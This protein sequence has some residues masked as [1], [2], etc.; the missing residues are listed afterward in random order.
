[1]SQETLLAIEGGKPSRPQPIQPLY[2]V[3]Q[4]TRDLI[5]EILDSGQFSAWYG[6]KVARRFEKEFAERMGANHA[7]AVNSGTSA[8][9]AAV[10]ALGLKSDDEVIVPA[11]A[12]VSA[13][14]V[15][16]QEGAVPVLCDIDEAY[17]LSVEDFE[18]RI[19]DKTRAVIVVHFWGY[20]VDMDRLCEIALRK[21]IVV[22]EDCGQS[23]GCTI[24][25]RVTGSIGEFGCYS[26]APRKHVT[27]GEGGM[28]TC[29]SER[30]AARVRELINKGK[31][32][33]WLDYHS[34]GF[35][36]AMPELDAAIGLDS[37][38][39]LDS[40]LVR[41]RQAAEVYRRTLAHT[42]LRIPV[43]PPYGQHVY[44]K[45]PILLPEEMTS[46]RDLLCDV[47]D[48][49][50]VSCRVPH[51]PVYTI[52]WLAKY[53]ADRGRPFDAE[54]FPFTAN[55]LPRMIE[56]ESGPNLSDEDIEVSA[57]AVARAWK[58][59]CS[60]HAYSQSA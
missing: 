9:H 19:T 32:N 26:F 51:P 4:D 38:R 10:A 30:D 20:P 56:V 2:H 59:V 17:V 33:G 11:A 12:Y 28:V 27:T 18:R 15:V 46:A 6:G 45:V 40:E 52:G 36:Y 13:A 23:H 24:G 14:S 1:M 7:I 54:S 39:K 42:P 49:E 5:A 37:L 22:I 57:N 44:F 3:G 43:D 16:V 41:R 58:Y 25:T 53:A 50:N 21:G 8:L 48:K 55:L 31:G 29:K 47:I 35:S 34:L 60:R